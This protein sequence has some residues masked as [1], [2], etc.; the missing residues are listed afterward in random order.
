MLFDELKSKNEI[1]RKSERYHPLDDTHSVSYWFVPK[2]D[3]RVLHVVWFTNFVNFV[4]LERK[5][6]FMKF[7]SS[8][9]EILTTW[10]SLR[11]CRSHDTSTK[12]IESDWAMKKGGCSRYTWGRPTLPPF[13]NTDALPQ[14]YIMLSRPLENEICFACHSQLLGVEQP[15]SSSPYSRCYITPVVVYQSASYLQP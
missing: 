7:W 1:N 8:S 13:P 2:W 14:A 5:C 3:Q 11:D 15:P 10:A 9:K 6:E 12:A 4:T